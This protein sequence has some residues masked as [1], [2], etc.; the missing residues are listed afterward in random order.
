[1]FKE[2]QSI[3]PAGF[4]HVPYFSQGYFT[5]CL[6]V[7][8]NPFRHLIIGCGGKDHIVTYLHHPVL[9]NEQIKQI[10]LGDEVTGRSIGILG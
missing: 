2:S 3:F 8:N 6:N 1:M 10:R 9:L 5:L 7:G 4:E